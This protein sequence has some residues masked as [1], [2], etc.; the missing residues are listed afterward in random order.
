M[1]FRVKINLW[2][3]FKM[4]R[5]I[6]KTT[7]N[8]ILCTTLNCYLTICN[9]NIMFFTTFYYYIYDYQRIKIFVKYVHI[10]N[11]NLWLCQ[12]IFRFNLITPLNFIVRM[13]FYDHLIICNRNIIIFITYD[14]FI[15]LNLFEFV[16][17]N[18]VK[19]HQ[20]VGN[21]N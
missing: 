5:L 13:M 6:L 18:K 3:F 15:K 9:R 1:Y 7:S 17:F 16:Q 11:I 20:L 21:G 10:I 8:V 14:A 2:F 19:L 12:K 4:V